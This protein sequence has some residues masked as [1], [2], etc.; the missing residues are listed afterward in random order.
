MAVSQWL[1]RNGNGLV[2][3][4]VYHEVSFLICLVEATCEECSSQVLQSSGKGGLHGKQLGNHVFISCLAKKQIATVPILLLGSL[5]F[6]EPSLAIKWSNDTSDYL[7]LQRQSML[8]QTC[9]Y[10]SNIVRALQISLAEAK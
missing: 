2:V 3:A 6:Q 10:I 7:E 4:T 9:V 1:H 8:L 5:R